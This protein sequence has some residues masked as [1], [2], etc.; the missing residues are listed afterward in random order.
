MNILVTGASG[1]I[2]SVLLPHLTRAGHHAIPL[3]RAKDDTS[4][5]CPTWD[6]KTND[7]IDAVIHLAGENIAQRWTPSAKARI[8]DSRVHGTESISRALANLN[9]RP[10]V[11]LSASGIGFY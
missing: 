10:R 5:S 1:F 7:P 9:P 3:Q 2:G 4:L 11:L 8:R 6:I